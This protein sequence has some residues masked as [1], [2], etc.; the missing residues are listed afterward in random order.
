MQTTAL[1][2][3]DRQIDSTPLNTPTDDTIHDVFDLWRDLGGSD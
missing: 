1:D 3:D 2:C